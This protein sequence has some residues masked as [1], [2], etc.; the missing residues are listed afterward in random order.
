MEGKEAT[1]PMRE[2]YL[3]IAHGLL[4]AESHI[5]IGGVRQRA[6]SLGSLGAL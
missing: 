6:R 2:L 4:L 5:D 3:E 1:Q